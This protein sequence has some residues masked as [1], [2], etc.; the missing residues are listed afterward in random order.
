MPKTSVPSTISMATAPESSVPCH[1]STPS[2]AFVYSRASVKSRPNAAKRT[3][4]V[5]SAGTDTRAN[6][7]RDA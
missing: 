2:S 7:D 6:S 3:Y 1:A 4:S 5:E